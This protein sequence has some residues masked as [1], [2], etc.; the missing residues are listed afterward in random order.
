VALTTLIITA[1]VVAAGISVLYWAY[2][3]G[4]VANQ[5]YSET[6]SSSQNATQERIAF[7]YSAYSASSS[8]LTVYVINCGVVDDVGIARVY[9]WDSS[10][11]LIGTFTPDGYGLMAILDNGVPMP[12]E[13]NVLGVGDEGYFTVTLGPVLDPG[14]YAF[15]VVTERGRN[16]DGSFVV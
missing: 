11:Q 1:G 8:Q 12:I 4:T 13:D 14:S 2:S 5:E 15:R 9:I 16:F 6:I 3:W 10:S 7:E